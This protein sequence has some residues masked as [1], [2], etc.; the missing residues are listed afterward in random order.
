MVH[1]RW[2]R[3]ADLL[4]RMGAPVTEPKGLNVTLKFMVAEDIDGQAARARAMG[5]AFVAEIGDRPWNAR[6]FTLV[7]PDGFALTFTYG[8]LRKELS[9]TD[10]VGGKNGGG[11]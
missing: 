5:A 4:L 11:G 3:F 9:F 2:I 6:E 1:M 7:D 8:P 10:V